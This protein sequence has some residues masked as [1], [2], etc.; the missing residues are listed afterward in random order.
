MERP[1]PSPELI[2]TEVLETEDNREVAVPREI[3]AK[4]L[5]PPDN[6]EYFV[7]AEF[8]GNVN[9]LL[10]QVGKH[11]VDEPWQLFSDLR[12]KQTGR[13]ETE[14]SSSSAIQP[15]EVVHLSLNGLVTEGKQI[16]PLM[17]ALEYIG[18]TV[19]I[20]TNGLALTAPEKFSA[21]SLRFRSMSGIDGDNKVLVF[22]VKEK[23]KSN[24]KYGA[25]VNRKETE[26]VII[27]NPE[28]LIDLMNR[29]GYRTANQTEK[30]HRSFVFPAGSYL[31]VTGKN[32]EL[33]TS[34]KV[35]INWPPGGLSPWLEIEAGSEQDVKRAT[36][37]LGF[38]KKQLRAIS[39][40][41][42]YAEVAAA[43]KVPVADVLARVKAFSPAEKLTIQQRMVELQPLEADLGTV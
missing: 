27:S 17:T 13:Q 20:T 7:S 43:E 40:S 35:E 42:L 18:F 14:P 32:I 37:L 11:V 31:G 12:L 22:N 30:M 4:L 1:K 10:A 8:L 36:K 26:D 15:G 33:T 16:D 5:A 29:I 19:K 38:S 6:P 39:N 2:N 41:E 23:G 3:E 28:S 25:I 34:F 24:D 9:G 21:H